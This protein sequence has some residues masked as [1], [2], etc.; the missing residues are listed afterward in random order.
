MAALFDPGFEVHVIAGT[1]PTLRL[2]RP[3]LF[4]NKVFSVL[5]PYGEKLHLIQAISH[6][7]HNHLLARL[8][9]AQ[10]IGLE[11]DNAT[12][13]SS[14]KLREYSV[15]SPISFSDRPDLRRRLELLQK[16]QK[17]ENLTRMDPGIIFG[18]C[19][20]ERG[21]LYKSLAL[22]QMECD[23]YIFDWES[24]ILQRIRRIGVAALYATLTDDESSVLD[25]GI[26]FAKH[27]Q[28]DDGVQV[29][30]P[31]EDATKRLKIFSRRFETKQGINEA[32]SYPLDPS[33]FLIL[34]EKTFVE[35]IPHILMHGATSSEPSPSSVILLV[36]GEERTK[37]VLESMLGVT[38]GEVKRGLGEL[39]SSLA[40]SAPGTRKSLAKST[41]D[42]SRE[43]SQSPTSSA[44]G[45]RIRDYVY[46]SGSSPPVHSTTNGFTI[47]L[48]DVRAMYVA[49]TK[50]G[51]D[52]DRQTLLQ[53]TA[54]VNLA[55]TRTSRLFD[56]WNAAAYAELLIEIFNRLIHGQAIDEK[57][58][59]DFQVSSVHPICS[60]V[61]GDSDDD[62]VDVLNI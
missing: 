33:Q 41:L 11:L 61:G 14:D 38:L 31:D 2:P 5:A 55:M 48:V 29:F 36:D 16:R 7:G 50:S 43:R 39:L 28:L 1:L 49:A 23:K 45:Q 19:E 35:R 34:E 20:Y 46:P 58:V 9:S 40:P 57:N 42:V 13:V 10:V 37:M 4:A 3:I 26:A 24:R 56:F 54:K 18:R 44:S 25:V 59:F 62:P 22:D 8:S 32:D 51:G 21:R 52:Q 60:A 27:R 15:L 30:V 47:Y 53:M 12:L 17:T 6:Y